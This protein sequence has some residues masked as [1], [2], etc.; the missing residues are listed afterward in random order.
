MFKGGVGCREG[1]GYDVN[2]TRGGAK[3]GGHPETSLL[4]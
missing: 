3:G 2:G 4:Y 1:G